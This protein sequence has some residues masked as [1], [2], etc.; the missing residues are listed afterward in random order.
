MVRSDALRRIM[1]ENSRKTHQQL[2]KNYR[3]QA[4]ELI[5][6]KNSQVFFVTTH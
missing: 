2:L 3:K 1:F 4:S 6:A 5:S